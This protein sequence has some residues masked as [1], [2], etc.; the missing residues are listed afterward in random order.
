MKL[1]RLNLSARF[2][3]WLVAKAGNWHQLFA[4]GVGPDDGKGSGG[5]HQPYAQSVW[6]MRAIKHVAEPVGNAPLKFMVGDRDYDDAALAA[7][8][9]SPVVGL[10]SWADF[11]EAWVGW[12]KLK[13][14]TFLIADD[15]WLL[16]VPGSMAR[17]PLIL[18]PPTAMRHVVSG[19]QLIEM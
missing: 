1:S 11:A 4:R 14:E 15:S 3:S 10:D 2:A 16:T 7:F 19:G 17:S 12:Y 9:D 18:A 5:L 8:W 6:V 13:G